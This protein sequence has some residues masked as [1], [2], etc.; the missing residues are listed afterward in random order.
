MIGPCVVVLLGCALI[1]SCASKP[2]KVS[3]DLLEDIR[4]PEIAV[5]TRL[6]LTGQVPE[7]IASGTLERAEGVEALK[8]VV[9]MRRIPFQIRV[10]ALETLLRTPGLVDDQEGLR[11]V[12]GLLPTETDAP[13]RHVISQLIV[14]RG[15]VEATPALV[16]SFSKPDRS[17]TDAARPE[18]LALLEL[19][20]EKD[21]QEIVFDTFIEHS[22]TADSELGSRVRRDA[23]NL[24]SR[25]DASGELRVELLS[26]LLDQPPPE[27][28]PMLVAIR[29]GLLELRTIPLTGEELE[30]L[31][32]L[33]SDKSPEAQSWWEQSTA[34]VA[35]LDAQQ[36][37]GIRLRH[38]EALRWARSNA[39]DLPGATRTELLSQLESRLSTRTHRR[40]ATD[41]IRFRSED[42]DAYQSQMA[43]PDLLTALVVDEAIQSERVRSALFEQ[44]EADRGDTTT[45]YGGIVRISIREGEEGVYVAALYAPKPVMREND[46]SFVASPEMLMESTT[47][48]AHYHFHVQSA[49]NGRYAGPSDGDMAYAARYGRACLVFTSLD[50]TTLG[51][52]LYQPDG[53]VLD[54][55][56]ITKP[57]GNS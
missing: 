39:P 55:G 47:A 31:T 9:W 45:E 10:K 40:R 27:N 11:L 23:W 16:R 53:V 8:D 37:R 35:A 14:E 4:N 25:L 33:H 22:P 17:I 3:G 32:Q 15:W 46:T 49:K 28:D 21:I 48:L 30:W 51:V 6:T 20:R 24:L 44:A 36:R 13:V 56:E 26:G 52:D 41:V 57:T 2:P 19:H 54:L 12:V 43:W 34:A 5:A 29:R 50:E 18:H 7:A 38:I 42:L 1:A